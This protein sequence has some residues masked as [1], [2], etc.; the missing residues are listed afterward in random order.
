[1]G[2]A[3]VL[4]ASTGTEIV[5]NHINGVIG[6]LVEVASGFEF[7]DG[8]A[9]DLFGNDDPQNTVTGHAIIANNVIENLGAEFAIGVQLDG[10][11]AEVDITGNTVRFPQSNGDV[12]AS[13][14]AA[15]RSH[16]RISV[17]GNDVRR[18]VRAASTR[19]PPPSQLAAATTPDI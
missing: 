5:G 17:V 7:T 16:S 10:V 1:M 12:Q 14:I 11:S 6:V 9:I 19:I 4:V 2:G 3:I 13:G 18:W 15:F 8:D